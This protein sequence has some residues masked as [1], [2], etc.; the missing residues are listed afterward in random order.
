[1]PP[2]MSNASLNVSGV[3]SIA[4][5]VIKT[6]TSGVGVDLLGYEGAV[7]LF[8]IGLWTDGTHTFSLTES[9]D[10]IS[11]G[12]VGLGDRSGSL[13][14]ISSLTVD[15]MIYKV[16]YLGNKRYLKVNVTVTGSPV[17]GAAYGALVLRGEAKYR[18]VA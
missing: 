2:M 11:Y 7:V 5:A 13:P 3:Q 14:V 4:P 15:N 6:T 8:D 1:M 16:G 18:P 10:D 17:T 12:A 9:E